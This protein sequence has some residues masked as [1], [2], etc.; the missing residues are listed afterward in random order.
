MRTATSSITAPLAF[1]VKTLS[2]HLTVAAPS[3]FEDHFH[4][5]SMINSI[6][7]SI[8]GVFLNAWVTVISGTSK[9]TQIDKKVLMKRT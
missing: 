8:C 6:P 2:A 7:A 5:L 4:V 9:K 3:V 1:L